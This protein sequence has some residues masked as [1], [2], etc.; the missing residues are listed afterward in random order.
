VLDVDLDDDDDVDVLVG[1]TEVF[2]HLSNLIG[3]EL[4]HF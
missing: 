1:G 4:R 2:R 3:R